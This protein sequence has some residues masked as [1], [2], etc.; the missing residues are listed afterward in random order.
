MSGLFRQAALEKIS[1]PDQLDRALKVVRPLHGIGIAAIALVVLAGLAWGILSSAPVTVRGQGILLSAAGVAVVSSPG[2][3]HVEAVLVEP[4]ELVKKGQLVALLTRPASLDTIT[5]KQA[6][7][8]GAQGLLEL[9]QSNQALRQRM[10]QELQQD[11]GRLAAADDIELALR[12]FDDEAQREQ[13]IL[14][15]RLRVQAL[16]RELANM[17]RDYERSRSLIAPVDGTAVELSVNPGDLVTTGQIVM[18]LLT[19]NAQGQDHSLH[20]I[21]FVPNEDGKK[22]KVGM[23]AQVMPSTT[24][25]QKDGFMQGKVLSVAKIPSSREGI[26]RRLKNTTLVDTLLKTGAPFEVELKL[27]TD[28]SSYSGYKWSS[29][30]GPDISIDAGTIAWADMVVE[31]RRVISLALPFFD[32][33]FRWTGAR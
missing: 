10:R 15:A 31:R 3:G 7:L 4:G 20:A 12:H 18:R 25:P 1:N 21:V 29:G 26:M 24:T 17:E 14:E 33:L 22:I 30:K 23:D 13:D 19:A 2:D 5:A 9:R 28:P 6:E 8:Q 16:E 27:E 11:A 32:H